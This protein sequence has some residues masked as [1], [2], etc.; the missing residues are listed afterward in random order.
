MLS[1]E[2]SNVLKVLLEVKRLHL[3]LENLLKA[4]H[5]CIHEALVVKSSHSTIPDG[6]S[7]YLCLVFVLE[8][9][10]GGFGRKAGALVDNC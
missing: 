8:Q 6:V 9:L 1:G 2:P 3:V 4:P 5:A 10:S 7:Q